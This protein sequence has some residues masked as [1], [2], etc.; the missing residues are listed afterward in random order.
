MG[1]THQLSDVPPGSQVAKQ[2]I[3]ALRQLSPTDIIKSKVIDLVSM[4]LTLCLA[5]L[6]IGDVDEC[7][8]TFMKWY[9]LFGIACCK[10]K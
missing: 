1:V 7:R 10:A 2:F 9:S 6:E 4:A 3:N 8:R 5:D